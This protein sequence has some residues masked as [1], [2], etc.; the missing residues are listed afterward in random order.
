MHR[1]LIVA[2]QTKIRHRSRAALDAFFRDGESDEVIAI[3]AVTRSVLRHRRVLDI[4]EGFKR[5][6]AQSQAKLPYSA[7][8]S[9][10]LSRSCIA[11]PSY[12]HLCQKLSFVV[13]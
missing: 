2:I 5:N 9:K 12:R 7:K 10:Y 3:G 4:G 6:G 13:Q 1:Q 11:F 8:K